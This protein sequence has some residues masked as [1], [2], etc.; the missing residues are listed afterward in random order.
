MKNDGDTRG[1]ES[2]PIRIMIVDDH[3]MVRMGLKILIESTPELVCVGEAST[4][5]QAVALFNAVRPDVVLMDILMPDM[6]GIAATRLICSQHQGARIIALTSHVDE[7]YVKA[8]LD[9][10]A[11]SYLLK[12]VSGEELLLAIMD[13]NQGKATFT[14]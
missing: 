10:G 9:A 2:L 11:I 12:G 14:S 4:G 3:D 7:T 6:D 13:A 1:Q 5:D 8:A